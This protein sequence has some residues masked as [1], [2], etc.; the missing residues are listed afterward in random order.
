MAATEQVVDTERVGK[1]GTPMHYQAFDVAPPMKSVPVDNDGPI[2]EHPPLTLDE[3]R[4]LS[5]ISID[6]QAEQERLTHIT[7]GVG[8]SMTYAR[9][10]DEAKAFTSYRDG[11]YPMLSASVGVDGDSLD[12]VAQIVLN[13]DY[14]WSIIGSHIEAV[15]LA[16]KRDVN[17]AETVS[18]IESIV[19]NLNWS[20]E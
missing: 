18:Q 6:A 15:R 2:T 13:L 12:Q 11:D 4:S 20:V 7:P 5:L 10:V 9:K 16:S 3:V 14:H 19:N 8:Q 17:E 1:K